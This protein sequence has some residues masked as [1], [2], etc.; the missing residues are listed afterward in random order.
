M[1]VVCENLGYILWESVGLALVISYVVDAV[2]S[3]PFDDS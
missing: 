3:T 2:C 1:E